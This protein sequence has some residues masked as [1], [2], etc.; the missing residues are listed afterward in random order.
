MQNAN[1]IP[2]LQAWRTREHLRQEIEGNEEEAFQRL[3]T[4][5]DAM[6]EHDGAT[7]TRI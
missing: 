5:L 4:L 2:Y 7:C 1:T 6:A 3:P